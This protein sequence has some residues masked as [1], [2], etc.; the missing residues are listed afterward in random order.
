MRWLGARLHYFLRAALHGLRAS[1][2][3]SAVA[4][5]T[6]GVTLLLVGAFVLLVSNMERLLDRFGEDILVSA[7]LE[8]GLP[9]AAQNALVLRVQG[10]P[11]V[12]SVRLDRAFACNQPCRHLP[13]PLRAHLI[14][15]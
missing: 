9:E 15:V 3:T 11:G 12:E 8:G 13:A 2:M 10:A 7:Y 6:I 5:A 4:V 14:A 1:L